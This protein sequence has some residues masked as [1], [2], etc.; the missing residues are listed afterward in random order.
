MEVMYIDKLLMTHRHSNPCGNKALHASSLHLSSTI[1]PG[2]KDN[3]GAR[4]GYLL[5]PGLS[6]TQKMCEL[7]TGGTCNGSRTTH[8]N[9]GRS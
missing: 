8:M 5:T 3:P 2:L 1:I 6:S 4:G 9:R 7:T